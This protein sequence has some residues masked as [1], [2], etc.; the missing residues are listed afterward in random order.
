MVIP[1]RVLNALVV[2]DDKGVCSAVGSVLTAAGHRVALASSRLEALEVVRRRPVHFGIVDV[3]VC[4]D[5]GLVIVGHL[6]TVVQHFPVIVMSGEFTPEIVSRATR[7]G[8]F[9]CL[10]K[11]LDISLLRS[12]VRDLIAAEGWSP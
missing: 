1:P 4:A 10:E 8:V 9:Q 7:L 5:D 11:P 6:R 3:H 12:A 2:D